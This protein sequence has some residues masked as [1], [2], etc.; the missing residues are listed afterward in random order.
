L[1]IE[2]GESA[3]NATKKSKKD[4]VDLEKAKKKKEIFKEFFKD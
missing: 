2:G 3:F 1:G 4:K